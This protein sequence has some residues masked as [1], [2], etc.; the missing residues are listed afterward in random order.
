WK[1]CE[2]TERNRRGRRRRVE[3]CSSSLNTTRTTR[4]DSQRGW[5]GGECEIK[6]SRD[7][8]S[9]C[10]CVGPDR[11]AASSL[12]CYQRRGSGSILSSC[13]GDSSTASWAARTIREHRRG[14]T[15]WKSCENSEG[16]RRGRRRRLERCG[17]SFDTARST[18]SDRQ[19]NWTGS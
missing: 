10:G 19:R 15:G 11:R 17:R 6:E 8:Q 3:S 18:I 9:E 12:D 2:N 13:K 16:N 4:R 14:Y 7:N 1:S 5:G